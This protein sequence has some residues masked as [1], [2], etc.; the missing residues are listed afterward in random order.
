MQ[1]VLDSIGLDISNQLSKATPQKGGLSM[2]QQQTEEDRELQKI[3]A[4]MP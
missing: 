2:Q 3:L 4:S 1:Q